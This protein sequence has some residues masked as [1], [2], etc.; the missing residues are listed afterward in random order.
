MYMSY[1]G[2]INKFKAHN[3]KHDNLLTLLLEAAHHLRDNSD[4]IQYIVGTNEEPNSIVVCEVWTSQAAHD[5][6]LGDVVVKRIME[7]AKP[8]IDS[9]THMTELHIQGAKGIT[10]WG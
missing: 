6:C 3:N 5:A 2:S 9:I 4:C 8:L 7:A 1:Y 10:N